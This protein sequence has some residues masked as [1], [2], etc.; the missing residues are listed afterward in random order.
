MPVSRKL[1]H[2]ERSNV[3]QMMLQC[4]CVEFCATYICFL[5]TVSGLVNQKDT[6]LL[7]MFTA[8]H[9]DE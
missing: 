6:F 4:W 9:W 1:K 3:R 8:V 5:F 2:M 7:L